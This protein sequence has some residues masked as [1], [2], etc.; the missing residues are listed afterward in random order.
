LLDRLLASGENPITAEL[1]QR[2]LGLPDRTLVFA[3]VDAIADGDVTAALSHADEL[4]N[5]GIAQDQLVSILIEHLR[6]LMLISA[7]GPTSEI[8]EM[9]DESRKLA[10][11]QAEKFDTPAIVHMIALLENVGRYAKSSATPRALLDA[12]IVR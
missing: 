8:V 11:A 7:C 5:R 1:L 2:M 3:L 12:A 6:N 10:A 4:I 9:D